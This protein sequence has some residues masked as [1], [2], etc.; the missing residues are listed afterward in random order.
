MSAGRAVEA[1][2]MK[3]C[4]ARRSKTG[5]REDNRLQRAVHL[6]LGVA[7]GKGSQFTEGEGDGSRKQTNGGTGFKIIL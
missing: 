4:F 3:A 1:G 7:D 6:S 5:T 2:G